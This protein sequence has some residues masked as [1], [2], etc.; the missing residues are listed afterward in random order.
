MITQP[1][2]LINGETF[3]IFSFSGNIPVNSDWLIIKVNGCHKAGSQ[4]FNSWIEIPSWPDDVLVCKD[5]G[6]LPKLDYI[7]YAFSGIWLAFSVREGP[8]FAKKLLKLTLCVW[9]LLIACHPE[10][11]FLYFLVMFGFI[12]Y[13]VYNRRSFLHITFTFVKSGIV[14]LDFWFSI[15]IFDERVMRVELLLE[16][17]VQ[18]GRA[19]SVL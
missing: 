4:Y 14:I 11:W 13:L 2:L 12:Y 8:I 9:D 17:E 3:A 10:I 5:W 18:V 19:I 6:T 7:W 15:H 1:F 16:R